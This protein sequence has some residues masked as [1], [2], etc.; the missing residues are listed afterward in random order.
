VAERQLELNDD[1]GL[2]GLQRSAS[3]QRAGL[4]TGAAVALSDAPS[5]GICRGPLI[6][7][8]AS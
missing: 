6:D 4:F 3:A 2:R 8:R 1:G 7:Q 5:I